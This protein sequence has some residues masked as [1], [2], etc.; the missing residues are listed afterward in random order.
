M[1]DSTHPE[2][3]AIAFVPVACRRRHDGWTPERQHRFLEALAVAGTVAAAA[4]AVGKSATAAYR[5]RDRPDAADF[6]RAWDIAQQMA[7]ERAF[8][9]AM[10]RAIN[11]YRRPRY[12]AGR[13]VGTVHAYDLRLALAVARVPEPL[14]AMTPAQQA[15]V[16]WLMGRGSARE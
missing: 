2:P 12:Y 10:E 8:G 7:Q 5:L 4:R 11:G 14:P 6:A 15:E 16:D 1:T 3:D 9:I 13:Q